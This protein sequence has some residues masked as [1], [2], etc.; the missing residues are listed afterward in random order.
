M[1]GRRSGTRRSR[2]GIRA[3][4]SAISTSGWW[5]VVSAGPDHW[6]SGMPSYPTTEAFRHLDAER[7]AVEACQGAEHVLGVGDDRDGAVAEVEQMAGGGWR[8]VGLPGWPIRRRVRRVPGR[9]PGLVQGLMG[10][11][12]K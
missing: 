5:T 10:V 6:A 7:L 9:R 2:S 4:S 8:P 3:A 12:G 1:R 11:G